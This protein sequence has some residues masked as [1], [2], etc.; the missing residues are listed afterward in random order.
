MPSSL[1]LF[2]V[3]G[4]SELMAKK[5]PSKVADFFSRKTWGKDLPPEVADFFRK[6]GAQGGR[7]RAESMTPERRVQI[8]KKAA[9]ARWKKK[10]KQ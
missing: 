9:A 4:Y 2:D 1:E 5:L 3:H 8:A 10:Q 7:A 6:T